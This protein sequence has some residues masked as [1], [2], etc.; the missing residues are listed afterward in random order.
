MQA[1]MVGTVPEKVQALMFSHFSEPSLGKPFLPLSD[2][3]QLSLL[4][5]LPFPDLVP[6]QA[7][8]PML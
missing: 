7:H 2:K 8:A 6:Q 1:L 4:S 3:D 5:S